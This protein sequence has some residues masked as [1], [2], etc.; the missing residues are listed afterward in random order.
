MFATD[1]TLGLDGAELL[2]LIIIALLIYKAA[3]VMLG[4]LSAK[5]TYR[6]R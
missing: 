4:M 5:T 3:I 1:T 6:K 2:G